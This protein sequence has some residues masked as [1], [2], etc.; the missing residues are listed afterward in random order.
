MRTFSSSLPKRRA[1][2]LRLPAL[3]PGALL[4]AGLLIAAAPPAPGAD[5]CALD[6]SAGNALCTLLDRDVAAWLPDPD[7]TGG[8][9]HHRARRYAEWLHAETLPAGGVMRAFFT[10]RLLGQLDFYG[11][12][13]DPAIWTGAY[14]AAESLRLMTTGA[15]DA[16][17]R[18]KD[19]VRVLDR[20]WRIS[21]DPGYLARYAAPEDS[22]QPILDALDPSDAN[23]AEVHPETPFEGE[24][25]RWR[26]RTSRDQYQGVLLGFSLAYEATEDERVKA[27]IRENVV[28]FAEQLARTARRSVEIRVNGRSRGDVELEVQ[29]VVFND[30]ETPDGQPVLEIDTSA[31]DAAGLGVLVFWPRPADFIRQIPWLGWFPSIE[32]STRAIQLAATFRVALQV[33]GG[34][35]GWEERH[36]ALR[37]HYE[38]HVGG[39]LDIAADYDHEQQCGSAY[40][41]IN[42]GF[43]P[44]Y[45]WARLETDPARAAR[46]REE[47]LHDGLWAEVV[48]H[49][50]VFFAFLYAAQAPAGTPTEEITDFHRDQLA[51]FPPPPNVNVPVDLRGD[52]RYPEDPRCPGLSEV[53]IDIGD[54][55][56]KSF[57]WEHD[58]WELQNDGNARFL[59][60]GVDYLLA[61]W[62]GRYHGFIGE[63]A[64]ATEARWRLQPP[65]TAADGPAQLLMPTVTPTAAGARV[66]V[67]Y[68][69][70]GP[71]DELLNGLALRVHWDSF[72]LAETDIEETLSVGFQGS[73][74]VRIDALD[75]DGD[76]AT[77]R[78]LE[79]SWADAAGGWPG[80]GTTPAPLFTAEVRFADGFTGETAL[81]FSPVATAPGYRLLAWRVPI[82]ADGAFTRQVQQMYVG[83]YGR[84]GDPQGVRYWAERLG[85][86]GGNW[87]PEI[88][89][90]FGTSPEYL[91][92]FGALTQAQ[93]IDNLYL[94]LF[95]RRAD[96]GGLAFYLD[97]LNGTNES[98]ENPELRQSSL[99]A[100]ALDIANG[101]QNA[102]ASALGNKLDVAGYF[103]W[104][105]EQ[106][107]RRYRAEDI[108]AAAGVLDPVGA[109][110]ASLVPQILAADDFVV[111]G[112]MVPDD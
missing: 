86:A 27:L 108:D 11:G 72:A 90:A 78:Y 63:D 23:G 6:Q 68:Q 111:S 101:A 71:N 26:S 33:T 37:D 62:L 99:A 39:W 61:Y 40:F 15:P 4:A 67:F 96:P 112:P 25:W 54:R 57:L 35:P 80:N 94:Q 41:G 5:V 102:D 12:E 19:T 49:K 46:I 81:G 20:W 76:P 87:T 95:G 53:A 58:P 89:D 21:G 82:T 1:I 28:G 30:D 70:V 88:V 45:N 91:D 8:N 66:Q 92:R 52:P 31:R 22:P 38:R 29:H 93:L 73:G 55:V 103:T 16:A 56:P 100:I 42:I 85:A 64:P 13:R 50:N 47:V 110:D 18:V 109:R 98:G 14:L 69:P 60:P 107:A 105:V 32:S 7:D 3:G 83:Y 2:R 24:P 97:L 51:Q 10:D 34:V 17:A 65:P 84:P 106:N 48:H 9:L 79:L 75:L 74:P 44:L 77:D 59:Y 36:A 104:G 43:M